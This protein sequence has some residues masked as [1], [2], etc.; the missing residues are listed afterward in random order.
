MELD[1]DLDTNLTLHHPKRTA[2]DLY[3]IGSQILNDLKSNGLDE[4]ADHFSKI[5]RLRDL[6]YGPP[7]AL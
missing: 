5:Q 3:I 2:V 1:V 4:Y 6:A 7:P